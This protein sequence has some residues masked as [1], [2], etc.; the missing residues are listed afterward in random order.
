D[1]QAAIGEIGEICKERG[2]AA[3]FRQAG[4]LWTATSAA[5]LGAWEGVVSLCE[6]LGAPAFRRLPPEEVARRS[7]SAVHR[8][9]VFEASAATVQPAALAR[10]L[11]RVALASGVRIFEHTR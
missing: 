1:S 3:D 10:G 11:R 5:Q 9:G 7:G 8:A 2:I 6:K 4:W